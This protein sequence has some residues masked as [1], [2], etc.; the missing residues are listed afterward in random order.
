MDFLFY[1]LLIFLI[2]NEISSGQE[3][4]PFA[5]K[6]IKEKKEQTETKTE[7][8]KGCGCGSLSREKDVTSNKAKE[9][10][11]SGFCSKDNDEEKCS[12]LVQAK[13]D[14]MV[15]II[16]SEFTMGTDKP[17]FQADGEFPARKVTVSDFYMD[18]HEVSNKDFR[19]FVRKTNHKTEA[20]AFGDSFV[21]E[22]LISEETKKGISKA[23]AGAP[24]W[25][26]VKGADWQHP[27][28]PDSDIDERMDHPVVHVS[29]ND[30]VSY[31][32]SLGKRLPTEAEW[33]YA[34]RGGLKDR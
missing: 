28:G 30:A 9:T 21:L 18:I 34:C 17:I 26:P 24:W 33:E 10:I 16:G 19:D 12:N 23:V 25:L 8:A 4:C 22:N 2:I 32:K 11:D 29:W 1:S 14:G 15:L 5:K 20:E 7:E 6:A 13:R 31:C 27:E 3:T